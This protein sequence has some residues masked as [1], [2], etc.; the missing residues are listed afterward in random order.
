[1]KAVILAAGKGERLEPLTHTRPK[2][3]I[4]IMDKPLL[5][6]ILENLSRLGIEEAI[7]VVGYMKEKIENTI[8]EYKIGIKTKLVVQDKPLG[9][10]HALKVVENLINDTFLLIY[11]DVFLKENAIKKILNSKSPSMLL[12]RVK[13]PKDYGVVVIEGDSI[14]GIVEK[15]EE[16][17][18]VNTINAGVYL[19]DENVFS[20]IDKISLS[21][22]GEYELTDAL[23]MMLRD[24]IKLNYVIAGE[25]EWFE[26][27]KPW[28][29]LSIHEKL[30]SKLSTSSINGEVEEYVKVKGPVIIKEGALIRSGTY[31]I[32]PAYIG[33]EAVI[34]PN[35]YI[36]PYSVIGKGS[37]IGNAVEVKNSTLMEGVHAQHLTYIGDSIICEHV[38]LGAG[39]ITAN[40]RFDNGIVKV[41]VKGKRISSGRRKLGAIIG[42]YVKTG[43]NVSIMPGVKIGAYSWIAPGVVVNRDIPPRSF[44]RARIE[45]YVEKLDDKVLQIT[46]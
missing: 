10:G 2:P 8:N 34:G 19:L 14:K 37:R 31:I 22:R 15:P 32:G 9:T 40:L 6:Y 1:M 20:Y 33:E 41:T 26:I 24:G 4:P 23:K 29:L 17:I 18:N 45:Y 38:N 39:T 3:L 7:I 21:V 44:L 12:T 16:D 46:S 35:S 13:N 5:I 36:R 43:I 42:G 30:L 27:G 25:D 28:D 11:G